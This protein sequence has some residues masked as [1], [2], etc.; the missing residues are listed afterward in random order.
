MGTVTNIDELIGDAEE[1]IYKGKHYKLPPDI[2]MPTVFKLFQMFRE[3]TSAQEKGD[4][5]ADF[6]EKAVES[7][8]GELFKL[9]KEG[10][11]EL[12]ALPEFGVKAFRIVMQKIF[13]ALNADM[14]AEGNSPSP[15]PTPEPETPGE[16]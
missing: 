10:D 14:S 16:I 1:I 15:E 5:P 2:P 13:A 12:D 11:P 8:N 7:L 3:V 9:F 4:A 6:L